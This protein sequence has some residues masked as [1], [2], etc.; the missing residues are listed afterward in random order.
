MHKY[1]F[2]ISICLSFIFPSIGVS[3]TNFI[4]TLGSRIYW[5]NQK[6]G[7]NQVDPLWSDSKWQDYR[8]EQNFEDFVVKQM[9]EVSLEGIQ[10]EAFIRVAKNDVQHPQ[11]LLLTSLQFQKGDSSRI[12]EWA[13]RQYGLPRATCDLSQKSGAIESIH[14]DAQWDLLNSRITFN[15]LAAYFPITKQ[16]LPTGIALSFAHK[17]NSKPLKDLLA[18]KCSRNGTYNGAGESVRTIMEDITIIVDEN[19]GQILNVDKFPLRGY[20]ITEDGISFKYEDDRILSEFSINRVTGVL[21]GKICDAKK[22]LLGMDI[23]GSC[24]QTHVD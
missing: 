23:T 6:W 2:A 18:I 4:K 12:L 21:K 5:E 22:G 14:I 24:E 9:Q 15:C 11:Q 8:G 3:E 13:I 19:T 20:T 17:D 16:F 7:Q 10:F 1:V